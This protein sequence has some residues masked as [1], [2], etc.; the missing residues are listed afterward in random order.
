MQCCHMVE[1][2]GGCYH[3]DCRCGASFCYKCGTEY[4]KRPTPANELGTPGCGCGL[5]DVPEEAGAEGVVRER[6]PHGRPMRG[7]REVS[8]SR[9][10]RARSIH[11]CRFRQSCWFWHDEDGMDG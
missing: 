7:G 3:M 4:R 1:R 2:D 9:C 8:N 5:F 10:R 11:D 6:G